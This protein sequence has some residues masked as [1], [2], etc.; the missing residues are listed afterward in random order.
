M[1]NAQTQPRVG[2][3]NRIRPV[4]NAPIHAILRLHASPRDHQAR[5]GHVGTVGDD[6]VGH[7][8]AAVRAEYRAAGFGNRRQQQNRAAKAAKLVV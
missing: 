5:V 7:S 6:L 3:I 4:T 1:S 8:R 2:S